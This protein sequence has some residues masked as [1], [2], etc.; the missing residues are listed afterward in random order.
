[1]LRGMRGQVSQATPY[2]CDL[3]H[4]VIVR[5]VPSGSLSSPLGHG[6]DTERHDDRGAPGAGAG[7]GGA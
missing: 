2:P 5:T 1:M 6:V 4:A 3:T 7:A